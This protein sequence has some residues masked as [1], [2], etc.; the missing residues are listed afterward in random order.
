M[1]TRRRRETHHPTSGLRE[2]ERRVSTC[3]L[4]QWV[5]CVRGVLE[6]YG[7][8]PDP[9]KED[10]VRNQADFGGQMTLAGNE[11]AGT[12]SACV[13]RSTSCLTCADETAVH[14]RGVGHRGVEGGGRQLHLLAHRARVPESCRARRVA[15]GSVAW[16]RYVRAVVSCNETGGV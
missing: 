3:N 8:A 2:W 14:T 6:G 9:P 5:I 12:P 1:E 4:G 11:W 10:S 16:A 7:L 13:G 15:P